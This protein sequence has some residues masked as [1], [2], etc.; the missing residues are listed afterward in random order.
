MTS[1]G[2]F[3]SSI[4]VLDC[5]QAII[6]DPDIRILILTA[7]KNLATAF[8]EEVRNYF[9]VVDGSPTEFQLLFPEFCVPAGKR[10]K[11]NE[12]TTPARRTYRK[13]PS[14]WANSIGSNLPGWH[15]DILKLDDVVTNTNAAEP[16]QIEKLIK[17]VNFARKLVDPGG[18]TDVIGT[19]YAPNDLYYDIQKHGEPDSLKTLIRPAW[20]VKP[21]ATLK[22]TSELLETDVE[23]LFPSRLTFKFL[24]KEQRRDPVTFDSQYLINPRSASR[25]VF[26]EDMV[27]DAILPW[28]AIPQRLNYYAAWDLAYKSGITNNSAAGAIIA[29]DEQARLY[30][31]D[32][33]WGKFDQSELTFQIADVARRHPLQLCAIEE[34]N[35]VRWLESEIDRAAQ[36]LGV[37]VPI[38]WLPVDRQ[39][40]AKM[41]RVARL[42]QL[43]KE[44]RLFISSGC[45]HID[46]II[47]QFANFSG[48]K[49]GVD[50]IPDCISFFPRFVNINPGQH[51]DA[52]QYEEMW[53]KIREQA[54]HDLLYPISDP[55]PVVMDSPVEES[56]EVIHYF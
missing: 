19:P 6:C 56:A 38:H 4:D 39:K 16:D 27:R 29:V 45:P 55:N 14:I 10:E 21:T 32:L 22:T 2:A 9:T 44:K 1:R 51:I 13:E 46:D 20:T 36:R 25:F 54:M 42:A 41:I 24:R 8:A 43:F 12:F 28:Q 37:K 18:Y 17:D 35:G 34:A 23:L 3:K 15:C 31:M 33:V 47:E 49:N 26:T 5:V 30:L 53:A 11:S 40:D 50:D 52:K 7:E 48:S